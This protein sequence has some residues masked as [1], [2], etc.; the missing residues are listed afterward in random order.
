MTPLSVLTAIVFGLLAVAGF[1]AI[2]YYAAAY[3]PSSE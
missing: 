3:I 1:G 2:V